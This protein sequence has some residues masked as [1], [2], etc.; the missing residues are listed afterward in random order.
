MKL[1]PQAVVGWWRQRRVFGATVQLG[2]APAPRSLAARSMPSRKIVFYV[3]H[4]AG[5]TF[6]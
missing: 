5:F 4:L 6:L 2:Q 1:L 3:S